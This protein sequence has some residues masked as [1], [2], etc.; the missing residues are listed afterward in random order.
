MDQ[1]QILDDYKKKILIHT[2]KTGSPPA[3]RFLFTNLFLLT[4]IRTI[5]GS[6]FK[7]L[8]FKQKKY[9]HYNSRGSYHGY[10]YNEYFSIDLDLRNKIVKELCRK[11]FTK[12]IGDY[13]I[14]THPRYHKIDIV[15]NDKNVRWDLIDYDLR[16]KFPDLVK[17]NHN[18]LNIIKASKVR[19]K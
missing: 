16:E 2:I 18:T 14:L 5:H 8:G 9:P 3:R 15:Y 6:H 11:S 17:Q 19:I 1:K 10:T 4:D 12:Y 7:K 13:E